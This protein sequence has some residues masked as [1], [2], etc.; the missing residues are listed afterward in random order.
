MT[1]AAGLAG[2]RT[3]VDSIGSTSCMRLRP[4]LQSDALPPSVADAYIAAMHRTTSN[5]SSASMPRKC[6]RPRHALINAWTLS[7]PVPVSS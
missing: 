6:S 3:V 1:G 2:T 4:W 7:G 5:P